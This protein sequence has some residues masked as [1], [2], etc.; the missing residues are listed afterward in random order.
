[1]RF[2][3]KKLSFDDNRS[4]Y[5]NYLEA[6]FSCCS[7]HFLTEEC[8]PVHPVFESLFGI[9]AFV[10]DGLNPMKVSCAD[11]DTLM[12]IRGKNEFNINVFLSTGFDIRPGNLRIAV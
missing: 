3:G 5:L 6:T 2:Y 8:I 4:I 1:L 11:G 10:E 7:V 12:T 9:M